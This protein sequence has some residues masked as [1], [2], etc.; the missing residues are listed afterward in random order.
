MSGHVFIYLCVHARGGWKAGA[1]YGRSG[2]FVQ[3]VHQCVF[4][5]RAVIS[6]M[7]QVCDVEVKAS[8]TAQGGNLAH[9]HSLS[10]LIT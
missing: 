7:N 6:Q 1:V 9:L 10:F 4:R 2:V 3:Y 5:P 8:A